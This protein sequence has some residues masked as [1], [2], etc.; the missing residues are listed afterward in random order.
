MYNSRVNIVSPRTPG[1]RAGLSHTTVLLAARE[2]L[3]K[4]G[5]AGLTMRALADHLGVSPN[6]LYSHV[7][8]KSALIDD[9]LDDVLG[10]VVVPNPDEVDSREGLR[11]LMHSTYVVLLD[12]PDLVPMYLVRHGARGANAHHLGDVM[13]TLLNRGGVSRGR[14]REAQRALIIHAISSAAY[15]G[16]VLHT[17]AGNERKGHSRAE[18]TRTFDHGLDW[19]LTGIFSAE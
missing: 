5:L 19:L 2:L 14:A 10:A 3:A 12:H 4:R 18:L 6:A 7:A 1:Q 9:L 17:S 13:T 15:A 11:L 8:T 16:V